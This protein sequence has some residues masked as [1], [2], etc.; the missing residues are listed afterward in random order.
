M[1]VV[2][3]FGRDIAYIVVLLLLDVSYLLS[4]AA[5]Q[6]NNFLFR[7]AGGLSAARSVDIFLS[8]SNYAELVFSLQN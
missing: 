3:N 1:V 8:V 2:R 7:S 6:C 5:T 4:S